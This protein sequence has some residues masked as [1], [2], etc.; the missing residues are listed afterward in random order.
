MR[1]NCLLAMTFLLAHPVQAAVCN[2]AALAG[3]YAFQLS[4]STDISGKPQP[5]SSL[6]RLVFDGKGNVTGTSSAMLAGFLQGNPVT[7][8][9]EAKEDCSLTWKLQDDSGA[10]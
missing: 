5:T 8:A 10:Y 3:P 4:G 2:P 6:G 1:L 7:G 9:Y